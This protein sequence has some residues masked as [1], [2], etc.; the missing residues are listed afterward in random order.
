[1]A[2]SASGQ[3][4]SEQRTFRSSQHDQPGVETF[5]RFHG[6]WRTPLLSTLSLNLQDSMSARRF[7]IADAEAGEFADATAGVGEDGEESVIADA[8]RRFQ[9]RCIQETPTIFR[10]ESDRL[11][12]AR[13]RRRWSLR[14]NVGAS[15]LWC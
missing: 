9:V 7:V 14:T 1:M 15:S 4:G 3:R 5:D 2:A 13:S 10:G 12:I 8:G 6:Q 11:A